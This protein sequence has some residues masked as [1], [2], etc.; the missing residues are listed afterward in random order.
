MSTY[1]KN[2]CKG[3]DCPPPEPCVT[4]AAPCPNPQPCTEIYD[5]QCVKYTGPTVT[6]NDNVLLPI[7]TS[8][9]DAFARL[10]AY[11]QHLAGETCT[12]SGSADGAFGGII[13]I[14]LLALD[15]N[16]E[17]VAGGTITGTLRLNDSDP[18]NNVDV[19]IY[20]SG[21]FPTTNNGTIVVAPDGS[22]VYTTP[23]DPSI[24]SDSY[25]YTVTDE[26]GDVASA[27]L[28]VTIDTSPPLPPPP[29]EVTSSG[30]GEPLIEGSGSGEGFGEIFGGMI[31]QALLDEAVPVDGVTA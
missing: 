27:T 1:N 17:V 11:A 22:F 4:P 12:S 5:A 29:L 10:I 2:N 24:A 18:D 13:G 21:T 28:F 15:D 9:A 26:D 30:S 25:V 8:I 14:A 31:G 7:G 6:C 19:L 3:C 20:Q 16:F 23:S